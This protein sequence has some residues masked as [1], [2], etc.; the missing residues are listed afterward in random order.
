MQ[1][2]NKI[3]NLFKKNLKPDHYF[4]KWDFKNYSDADRQTFILIA[5]Q[6]VYIDNYLNLKKFN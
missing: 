4:I 3:T 5:V 1:C 6:K 2:L